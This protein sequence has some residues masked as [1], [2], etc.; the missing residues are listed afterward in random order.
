MSWKDDDSG[1][2][3]V[4]RVGVIAAVACEGE[5][6]G[7]CVPMGLLDRS[8]VNDNP[9]FSANNGPTIDGVEAVCVARVG[10][11]LGL[12]VEVEV[13]EDTVEV[14]STPTLAVVDA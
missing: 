4:D 12:E 9:T 8:V 14:G 13:V 10:L 11:G 7:V 6:P 1:A 5:P 2:A 3:E